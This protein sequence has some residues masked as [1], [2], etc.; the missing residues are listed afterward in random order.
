M[1]HCIDD[2]IGIH[3]KF[4]DLIFQSRVTS[5]LENSVKDNY[6]FHGR[7]MALFSI[8]LNVDEIKITYSDK[9]RGSCIYIDVD[10][11]MIPEKKDQSI[12]PNLIER[13]GSIEACGGVGNIIKTIIDFAIKNSQINIFFGNPTQIIATMI[14]NYKSSGFYKKY[15]VSAK[16]NIPG[17]QEDYFNKYIEKNEIKITELPAFADNYTDLENI[18][19]KFFN[20]EIS[21][22]N[23]QR[24]FYNEV[25]PL[26]TIAEFINDNY[27]PGKT[28]VSKKTGSTKTN[29]TTGNLEKSNLKLYDE[30]KLANR[31]KDEEISY[32]ISALR[33]IIDDLGKKHFIAAEKDIEI[34]KDNNELNIK[35]NLRQEH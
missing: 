10:L 13:D 23:I 2:G 27:I 19:K 12:L 31:F 26:K 14:K 3:L 18:L 6:G 11:E 9:S 7:G 34:K 5:K 35:I 29:E 32:I 22:R 24:I 20:I 8:K 21:Q 16:T 30:L 17:G 4:H 25:E 33:R 28:S 15:A 1:I